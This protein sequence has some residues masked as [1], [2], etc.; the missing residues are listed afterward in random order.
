MVPFTSDEIRH[1]ASEAAKSAVRELLVA[2]GVDANDP[3]SLITMQK[4]F[5]H[6]RAWRESIETV[7]T[8]SITVAIG[9]I[10]VG[11]LGAIWM[12]IRSSH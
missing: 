9:T 1:I 8:K 12:A 4:D 11:V 2:M 10:V 6:L 7:K 3:K 5:A